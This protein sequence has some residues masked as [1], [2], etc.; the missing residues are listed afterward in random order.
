MLKLSFKKPELRARELVFIMMLLAL[1][2]GLFIGKSW[3][4]QY[5]CEGHMA[6]ALVKYEDIFYH[7][8]GYPKG[9]KRGLSTRV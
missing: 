1:C 8:R 3:D 5:R 6:L 9:C 2:K 7:V 4:I